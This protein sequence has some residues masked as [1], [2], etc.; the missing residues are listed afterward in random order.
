MEKSKKLY[1]V[2]FI[3]G[4]T[5]I[6]ALTISNLKK[7]TQTL[8]H[9]AASTVL[10]LTPATS[11]KQVGDTIDLDLIINP[12]NNLVSLIKFQLA[13]DS[14]KIA[15]EA[16]P[17]TLNTTA[18]PTKVEGPVINTES[19][20]ETVSIGA[21]PTKVIQKETKVGTV[22]FKAIAPTDNSP[23]SVT[24]TNITQALSLG[25][26]D[27][28]FESV[29]SS[30]TPAAITIGGISQVTPTNDPSITPSISPKPSENATTA[31]F[32]LQLHGVGSSGDNPNPNGSSL[33]NKT[34]LHPQRNLAILLY[35]TDNQ[36]VSSISGAVNYDPGSG[37]FKGSVDLGPSLSQGNYNIKIKTDRYLRK[38]IPGAQKITPLQDNRITEV[39]VVAGD[40]NSDNSV[41]ILDYNAFLDCGYGVLN[42]LPMDD[43]NSKFNK[44]VCQVHTPVAN[45][46][47][48]DNGIVDSFD[49][50]LFLREL[51]VQ[52]GD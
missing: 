24:F 2:G 39:A 29:L 44:K 1:L 15:L 23:I 30:T 27:K 50:N 25:T 28:A 3:L 16:D 43:P 38:L 22:H 7:P 20:G 45:I 21:D 26:G 14:K 40:T 17:F 42:P 6:S 8:T 18:F 34:P 9:A 11:S 48:D 4:L 51:S 13:F 49:Y 5:L 41:N 10:S 35:N 52:T 33:S 46:D 31:T 36:L 47:V 32:T 19:I 12:G 37:T